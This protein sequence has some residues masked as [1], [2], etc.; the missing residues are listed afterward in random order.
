MKEKKSAVKDDLQKDLEAD[1]VSISE[2]DKVKLEKKD[3]MKVVRLVICLLSLVL[4]LFLCSLDIIVVVTLFETLSQKFH[5]K[6]KI[7]W[8]VTAFSLPNALFSLVWG[9]LSH[10]FGRKVTLM[11]GIVVFELGSLVVALGNSMDMILAGRVVAG[12]GASC[13]MTMVFAIGTS[14]VSPR[15]RGQVILVLSFAFVIAYSIGPNMF[16]AI[17]D[18]VGW[19]WCFY[20]NLPIGGLA[21]VLF[22]L[23]YWPSKEEAEAQVSLK[24]LLEFFDRNVFSKIFNYLTFELDTIGFVLCSAAC[25][26]FL[27]ALTY[28]GIEYKWNSGLII[29]LLV[30][31]VVCMIAFL[32]HEL[33]IAPRFGIRALM[34][35]EGFYNKGIIMANLTIFAVFGFYQIL[36][37]YIVNFFQVVKNRGVQNAATQLWNVLLPALITMIISSRLIAR[38]GYLKPLMVFGGMM[39]MI[40]C[41]LMT[42]LDADTSTGQLIGYGI[43]SGIPFGVINQCSLISAQ[44][45]IDK[46]HPRFQQL[47]TEITALN[48]FAKLMGISIASIMAN[49]VYENYLITRTANIDDP[50][51]EYTPQA[52]KDTFY[53]ALGFACFNIVCSVFTSPK[54]AEKIS[55]TQKDAKNQEI[56]T[57]E[58]STDFHI[59]EEVNNSHSLNSDD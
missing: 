23:A 13:I 36:S 57:E 54:R 22:F 20:I 38:T 31:S 3:V 25:C 21:F 14:L 32:F 7:G 5:S 59:K 53:V 26:L 11:L 39:G 43:P 34:P 56:H 1:M 9:R 10:V 4:T 16:S 30:V 51:P 45:Q 28:A 40:G 35:Q 15:N 47:F 52:F 6:E 46:N 58:E 12:I 18:N 27:T 19:R 33:V 42:L 48:S 55:E 24:E 49:C 44:I 8:L 17:T 37:I 50:S 41:G 2:V 29:A